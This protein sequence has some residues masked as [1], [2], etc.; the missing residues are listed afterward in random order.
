MDEE[1]VEQ[2]LCHGQLDLAIGQYS[3]TI[4]DLWSYSSQDDVLHCI[5]LIASV[6]VR[7]SLVL[8]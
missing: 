2:L 4:G 8:T 3:T 5:I 7:F 6:N 1:E